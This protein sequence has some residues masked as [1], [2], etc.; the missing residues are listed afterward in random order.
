[1]ECELAKWCIFNLLLKMYFLCILHSNVIKVNIEI[2]LS[3]LYSHL[4][5]S[6]ENV[7]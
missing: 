2:L 6:M 1:M 4:I 7:I 3:K 5:N